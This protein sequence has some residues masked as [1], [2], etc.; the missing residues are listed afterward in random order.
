[1]S[2]YLA[3]ISDV[4]YEGIL[5]KAR[6]NEDTINITTRFLDGTHNVQT[7]GVPATSVEVEFYCALDVKRALQVIASTGEPVK[8]YGDD[9]VFTGLIKQGVVKA[10]PFGTL[11]KL[12]FELLVTEAVDR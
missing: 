2:N 3:S 4:A 11:H 12:S 6:D 8:V 10:E 1:M 9:K 5:A 7:I